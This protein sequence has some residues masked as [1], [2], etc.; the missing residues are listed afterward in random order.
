MANRQLVKKIIKIL[1]L[2]LIIILLIKLISST[3]ARYESNANANS[4]I[5]AAFYVLSDDFQTMTLNLDTL[6][7]SSELHVYTFSVSNNDGTNTCETDMQYDLIIRTTTNLPIE[8]ELYMNQNYTDSDAVSAIKTNEVAKDDDGT[9]FRTITTDTQTFLYTKAETN[10]YQLVIKFPEQ[11]NNIEYQDVI[12][13]IEI[14]V[15]SKQVI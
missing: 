14:T 7:P 8:Y 6:I 9:Y 13:A 10:T 3:V 2:L 12:E 1:I 11:Y 15:D 5:Q 4:N